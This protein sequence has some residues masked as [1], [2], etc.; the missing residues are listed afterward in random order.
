MSGAR[1]TNGKEYLSDDELCSNVVLI[2][3]PSSGNHKYS[4]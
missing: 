3:S 2:H 1:T 4:Y